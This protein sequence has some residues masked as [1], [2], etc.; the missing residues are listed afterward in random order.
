M[1]I[2]YGPLLWRL[3]ALLWAIQIYAASSSAALQ[4]DKTRSY[5]AEWMEAIFHFRPSPDVVRGIAVA[6]RKGAHFTEFAILAVLVYGAFGGMKSSAPARS[7]LLAALSTTL[8]YAASDEFH[9]LFVRGRGASLLDWCID[10]LGAACGLMAAR[11]TVDYRRR[12]LR[13]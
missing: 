8:V 3:A 2:D 10:A 13:V 1:R 4:S 6:I 11:G 9:Q 7:V 5:L 12:S